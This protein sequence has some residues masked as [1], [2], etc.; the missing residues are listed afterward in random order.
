MLVVAESETLPVP[1]REPGVF[2]VIDGIAL[3]V[4][5]T[6]VRGEEHPLIS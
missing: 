1:H 3:T 5:T 2:E 6:E 4:A